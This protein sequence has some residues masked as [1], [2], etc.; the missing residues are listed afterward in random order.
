MNTASIKHSRS[1]LRKCLLLLYCVLPKEVHSSPGPKVN[2]CA[3]Q[4]PI[5]KNL[6]LIESQVTKSTPEQPRV[7]SSHVAHASLEDL[8]L[9]EN[10]VCYKKLFGR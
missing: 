2:I 1:I 10:T 7:Q 9:G 5:R 4:V 6:I 8:A 3:A